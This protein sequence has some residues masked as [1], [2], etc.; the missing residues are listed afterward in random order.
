[1]PSH[2]G[3]K[4]KRS[5]SASKL[6]NVGSVGETKSSKDRDLTQVTLHSWRPVMHNCGL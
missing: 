6:R 5:T 2:V 4:V 1:M 3:T